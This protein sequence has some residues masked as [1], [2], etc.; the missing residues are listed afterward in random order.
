[1][2]T[3]HKSHGRYT[4]PNVTN[5]ND[6]K[7]YVIPFPG[8][9]NQKLIFG[10]QKA[11]VHLAHVHWA[12]LGCKGM[13]CGVSSVHQIAMDTFI[14]FSYLARRRGSWTIL[15]PTYFTSSLNLLAEIR[16]VCIFTT[17]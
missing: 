4:N 9:L 8:I 7:K 12:N 6:L 2:I 3:N 13:G 15:C 16:G 14:T 10:S 11:A 5:G 1:M 17:I